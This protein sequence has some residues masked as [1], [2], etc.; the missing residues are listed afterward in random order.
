LATGKTPNVDVGLENANVEYTP[1][2]I[3]TNEF[4][5][6]S[7]KH[8]YAVG[9]V[10]GP[11]MFTHAGIYQSRIAAHNLLHRQ[12]VT[13][14]YRAMPRVMFAEPEL[15]AT[16]I[17]ED[18]AIKFATRYK[19]ASV[20]LSVIG[21]ANVNDYQDGFVKVIT[22]HDGRL[23]G[24]SI[25]APDAGEMIQTLTLAVQM[26]LH[27]HDVANTIYPYPTWSEAIRIACT[28]IK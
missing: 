14:D 26:R 23:I 11:Y 24:A 15:A 9:D 3:V 18:E 16:G 21:R 6:T 4:M 28:K 2:G 25:A 19:T 22:D 10:A 5:Q 1:K 12:K 7:C 20:P 17:T 8:I 27:A 13:A